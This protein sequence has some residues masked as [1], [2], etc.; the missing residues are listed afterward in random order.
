MMIKALVFLACGWAFHA[1]GAVLL[2]ES[3]L[4]GSPK[5]EPEEQTGLGVTGPGA[6]CAGPAQHHTAEQPPQEVLAQVFQKTAGTQASNTTS[7]PA[8]VSCHMKEC[9]VN[10]AKV[11]ADLGKRSLLFFGSSLDVFA[12]DYFCKSAGAPVHGIRRAS[13]MGFRANTYE[14]GNFAYCDIG[15]F[16]LAW[17]FHPGVSGPPYDPLC[18]G[19]LR[20]DCAHE[21][22][23]GLIKQSVAKAAALFGQQPTA[24]VVDSSLWDVATW[25]MQADKPKEPWVA[26]ATRV[27]KW[28]QEDFPVLVSSVQAVAPASK[29]AFRTAPRMKEG[30]TFHGN[31]QQ[32]MEAMNNCLRAS[33]ADDRYHSGLKKHKMIDYNALVETVLNN[34]GSNASI[35]LD[36]FYE[37][38]I[39]P[40]IQ[41]SEFYID[42]VMQWV[43]SQ[44]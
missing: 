1:R 12:L 44:K 24:I 13:C 39:H 42:H 17:S 2:S 41:P 30:A 34:Q 35:S 11:A 43:H 7:L 20:H 23:A 21:T 4:R 8:Y 19:L 22:S 15:G 28:C 10:V 3:A 5:L 18:K 37:D 9:Q 40:G 33:H 6:R 31:N 14:K 36:T 25:W 38:A 27:A 26:P 16:K 32:N 29:V